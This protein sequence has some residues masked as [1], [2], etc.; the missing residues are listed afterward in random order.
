MT[1]ARMANDTEEFEA[2]RQDVA[3]FAGK[4]PDRAIGGQ[5]VVQSIKGIRRRSALT[6]NGVYLSP[7]VGALR[8]Q[9]RFSGD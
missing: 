2:A 1:R 9:Y 3:E 8:R 7:K 6:E 4:N 5:D